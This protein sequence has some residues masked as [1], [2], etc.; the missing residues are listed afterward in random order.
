MEYKFRNSIRSV[1]L[2]RTTRI[3]YVD[4]NIV[5][6][7]KTEVEEAKI[8]RVARAIIKERASS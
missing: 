2:I 5:T 3:S 4:T 6:H 1:R 7:R 8:G